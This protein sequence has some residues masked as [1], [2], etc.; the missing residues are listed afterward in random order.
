MRYC[1]LPV[2][3]VTSP[4]SHHKGYTRGDG[5]PNYILYLSMYYAFQQK[6]KQDVQKVVV[7]DAICMH[8]IHLQQ[9]RVDLQSIAATTT[10]APFAPL[11]NTVQWARDQSQS[12]Q[13]GAPQQHSTSLNCMWP[14]WLV[15][16]S[17]S[18]CKVRT[19]IYR[20]NYVY[21]HTEIRMERDHWPRFTRWCS[22]LGNELWQ[23][24]WQE[25]NTVAFGQSTSWS[26]FMV[27]SANAENF[28]SPM[29]KLPLFCIQLMIEWLDRSCNVNV[30]LLW[31]AA[32]APIIHIL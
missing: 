15:Q 3:E 20:Y 19:Y 26:V 24:A 23:K 2:A 31:S 7:K 30:F 14:S 12:I 22:L 28:K 9:T 18:L 16:R 27:C 5:P 8:A 29:C 21:I 1:A 11:I 17:T 4:F 13:G 25:S 10:P 32:I 6:K